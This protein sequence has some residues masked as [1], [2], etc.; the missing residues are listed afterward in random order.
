MT[1]LISCGVCNHGNETATKQRRTKAGFRAIHCERCGAQKL[2]KG[3]K[4]SCGVVW[5]L[6]KVHR[7]DPKVHRSRKAP[8]AETKKKEDGGG[9]GRCSKRKA[10][11]AIER[12]VKKKA[13]NTSSVKRLYVHGQKMEAESSVI[14][15]AWQDLLR[16]RSRMNPIEDEEVVVDACTISESLTTS[17]T[18][19][20]IN[21]AV[22]E[23]QPSPSKKRRCEDQPIWALPK[24]GNAEIEDRAIGRLL[25]SCCR[26]D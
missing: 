8:K 21:A 24:R 2:A 20:R 5:H 7:V 3:L 13:S 17:N 25:R 12:S 1:R 11:E 22:A 18:A 14:A 6:C 10:L 23:G 9:K 15:K 19:C 16:K 26:V 4:R